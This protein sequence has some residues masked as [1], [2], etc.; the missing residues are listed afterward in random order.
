MKLNRREKLILASGILEGEGSFHIHHHKGGY[1]YPVIAICMTDQR[2]VRFVASV[3][4]LSVKGPYPNNGF[5]YK[6]KW[7]ADR[8]GTLARVAM[9][10]VRPFLSKNRQTQIRRALA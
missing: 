2:V 3:L 6:P 8:E 1:H 4:N 10:R 5:G 9:R 7:Y